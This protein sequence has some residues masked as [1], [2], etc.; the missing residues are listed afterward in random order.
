MHI[1]D[2][3]AREILSLLIGSTEHRYYFTE[4]QR[5]TGMYPQVVTMIL[6]RLTQTEVLIREEE[7][8]LSESEFR[9]PRVYYSINPDILDYLRL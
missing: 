9:A 5:E 3:S 4:I 2:R 6:G 1:W 7:R 8:N